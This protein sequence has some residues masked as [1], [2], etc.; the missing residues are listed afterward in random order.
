[1]CTA[2]SCRVDRDLAR[3]LRRWD[4]GSE[5]VPELSTPVSPPVPKRAKYVPKHRHATEPRPLAARPPSGL[6]NTVLFSS[7]A[8][9]PRPASRVS[10]GAARSAARQPSTA[11]SATWRRRPPPRTPTAAAADERELAERSTGASRA[12]PTAARPPTRSRRPRCATAPAR[13]S[14]GTEDVSRP[15]TRATSPGRCCREFG[16]AADQFS[17]LD[18][19]YIG[20]SGWNVAR[21]QPASSAYGI[22]QA[23]PGSKMASAGADWATN[24]GTQI[25]WG[26]GYIQRQL[27]LARAAPG[28]FKHGHGWY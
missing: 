19:L 6:R 5:I 12:P 18:S 2:R 25:R 14:P 21:R 23:L 3:D 9:S 7:G 1:M 27:R 26:L 15:T 8:P 11:A 24:A 17:C 10:G 4:A 20:E 13:R 28:R 22:P 16:F